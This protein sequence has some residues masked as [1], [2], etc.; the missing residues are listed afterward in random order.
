MEI[1]RIFYATSC[2]NKLCKNDE[3]VYFYSF[4]VEPFS[5]ETENTI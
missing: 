5:K 4:G 3:I 2:F 1:K